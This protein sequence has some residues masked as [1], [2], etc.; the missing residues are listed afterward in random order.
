MIVA[1][2]IRASERTPHG[3]RLALHIPTNLSYFVGHFPGCPVLPG[4]VQIAWAIEFGQERIPFSG[5]V[6]AMS[7]VKFTRVIVPENDLT[8][9]LDYH[10]DKQQLDFAY[11]LHGR[12]C[13]SGSILFDKH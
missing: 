10:P 4:V 13:S 12:S 3:V 7:A 8:L 6:R 1:P 11:D 2:D 9:Q 5:R